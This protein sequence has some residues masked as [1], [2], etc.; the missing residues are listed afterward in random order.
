MSVG[1]KLGWRMSDLGN[2][3]PSRSRF[4]ERALRL[5]AMAALLLAAGP[6]SNLPIQASR[7][8]P[9]P[10][11][12]HVLQQA[13]TSNSVVANPSPQSNRPTPPANGAKWVLTDGTPVR[14]RFVRAVDSSLVIAGEKEP[15][16]VV[17]AVLVGNFVAIPLHSPAQ[18]TVTLAQTKRTE[19][20]GGNL[21]LKIE[22]LRLADGELVP[23]RG[24]ENVKGEEHRTAAKVGLGGYLFNV[25]GKSAKIPVGTEITAYILGDHALDASKFEVAAANSEKKDRPQ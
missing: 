14:L 12:S 22:S 9:G 1:S 6:G 7:G 25:N 20:R 11:N 5:A 4:V 16:E 19:G 17:E 8:I 23:V 21:Q 15:M 18:A 24:F 10:E 2:P 13:R 3:S